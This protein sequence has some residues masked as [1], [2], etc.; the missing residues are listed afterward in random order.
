MWPRGHGPPYGGG[1][2]S[3]KRT[4]VRLNNAPHSAFDIPS[5]SGNDDTSSYAKLYTTNAKTTKKKT[6]NT[7]AHNNTS[8]TLTI[9]LVLLAL[10]AMR[11]FWSHRNAHDREGHPSARVS[12]PGGVS[13]G[14][15][16]VVVVD[17]D[18]DDFEHNTNSH[19][20]SSLWS[21][22][23]NNAPRGSRVSSQQVAANLVVDH[24]GRALAPMI[25]KYVDLNEDGAV[26]ADELERFADRVGGV[27]NVGKGFTSAVLAALTTTW[28]LSL[29]HISEPTRPY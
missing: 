15:D 3:S 21:R 26:D 14:G 12:A 2:G 5:S 28:G 9:G 4:S 8:T 23:T 17:D 27:E 22:G 13:V 25:S 6:R 1:G 18:D 29:I 19:R 10:T 11:V 7:N 20:K 16:F 24:L